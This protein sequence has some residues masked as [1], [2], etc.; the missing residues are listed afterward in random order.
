MKKF[1]LPRAGDGDQQISKFLMC[2]TQLN[3]LLVFHDYLVRG[4]SLKYK[5]LVSLGHLLLDHLQL[6]E[7][8]ISRF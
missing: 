8:V 2:D 7:E 5:F 4:F 3:L 1:V 6:F